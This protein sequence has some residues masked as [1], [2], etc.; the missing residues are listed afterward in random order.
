MRRSP[1]ARGPALIRSGRLF[2]SAMARCAVSWASSK[3]DSG[4]W[5]SRRLPYVPTAEED[6]VNLVVW[7]PLLSLE[8]LRRQSIAA[9][10]PVLPGM[11]V[12]VTS[13]AFDELFFRSVGEARFQTPIITAFGI[14]AFVLAGI[15]VFGLVSF[16][17]EQRT[18][19]FGIRIAIGARPSDIRRAVLREGVVPAAIGLVL[20]AAG[21]WAL[22]QVVESTAFGWESSAPAALAGVTVALLTIAV[23]AAI[24][25]AR[26]AVRIDPVVT[27]RAE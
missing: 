27:L 21:A 15:G 22:E 8:D 9:I 6:G 1:L 4:I 18:H 14:L 10:E 2:G 24:V 13:V 23:V 20:G 12:S 5:P 19:E 16:V 26:R 25:P 17:V 3:A 7:A 11:A